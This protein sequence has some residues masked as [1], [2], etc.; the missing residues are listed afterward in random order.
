MAE[1][2]ENQGGAFQDYYGLKLAEIGALSA[3][4][5]PGFVDPGDKCG[6]YLLMFPL[7]FHKKVTIGLLHITVQYLYFYA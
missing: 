6:D 2:R 4:C 1:F 5:A 3:K 7:G